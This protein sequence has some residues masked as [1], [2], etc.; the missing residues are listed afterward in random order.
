MI[1]IEDLTIARKYDLE[2]RPDPVVVDHDYCDI[3]TL[4]E[5]SEL[6]S[7]AI[8][9]IAGYVVRMVERKNPLFEMFGRVDNYQRK[10]SRP[11]RGVEIEWRSEVALAGDAQDLRGNRE[12]CYENVEC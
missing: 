5:L 2:L 12:M 8:S 6:K 4:M 7:S 11:A 3:P 9:Y 10:D 1:E